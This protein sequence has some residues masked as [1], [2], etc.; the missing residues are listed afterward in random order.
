LKKILPILLVLLLAVILFGCGTGSDSGPESP[1][2]EPPQAHPPVSEPPATELAVTDMAFELA[3][4]SGIKVH[5]FSLGDGNL[6]NVLGRPIPAPLDGIIAVPDS[7]G[8]HP[9]V[10]IL[11]GAKR[12]ET[13]YDRV[14]AGFD[15]L[16]GQLAAEGYVA[17]SFNINIEW[18]FDFGESSWNEWSYALFEQHLALLEE[19]NSGQDPGYG[20]DLTGKVDI[21]Q[22]HLIGHSRGAEVADTFCRRDE[23]AG[24]DRIRSMIRVAPSTVIYHGPDDQPHPDVPTSII[25]PEFDGDLLPFGQTVYDEIVMESFNRSLAS[26]VYLRGANHN[27]FNRDFE[28]DDRIWFTDGAAY[29]AKETWLTRDQQE[30]FLKH[31]A[32]AFLSLVTGKKAPWG[33]FAPAEPQPASMFGYRV[34]ASTY[35]PGLQ[36][37]LNTP[38]AQNQS[39]VYATGAA[40]AGFWLQSFP[41]E[42]YFT[43]PSVINRRDEQLPL[44]S[45]EW[46]GAGGAVSFSLSTGD[47]SGHRALSLYVAVDSSNELNPYGEDQSFTLSLTDSSGAAQSVFI[48]A[49]TGALTWHPGYVQEFEWGGSM[50]MGFMPL[51][52]LR[53][54]LTC[55]DTLDLGSIA[56]LTITFD[57]SPS[58]AVMLSG[59]YLK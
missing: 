11:H 46:D 36:S 18:T 47:F 24:L 3:D 26:L 12:I 39:D 21:D 54:P 32:A 22:I 58:G 57:R 45:L 48:P 15:Y 52:D 25:L 16:V 6:T 37:I 14:Y 44:Y 2:P 42:G 40:T 7:D 41:V 4:A 31:Y 19:A 51:G 10:I 53:V 28:E 9:L 49:G 35:I 13:V 5:D 50:W 20:V 55:F 34:T 30:D 1:A 27:F 38:S 43:H 29:L 59:I 8:P 23:L 56:D 33:T 17:V